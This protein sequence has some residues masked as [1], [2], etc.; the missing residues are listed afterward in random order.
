MNP[1]GSKE[2]LFYSNMSALCLISQVMGK[3]R[4]F[5][6]SSKRFQ[7]AFKDQV[8]SSNVIVGGFPVERGKGRRRAVQCAMVNT[9]VHL[10]HRS[11]FDIDRNR[12][13]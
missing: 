9:Q 2:L 4:I 12:T 1:S 13:G 8:T 7:A 11:D 5:G 6:S 3:E 10:I